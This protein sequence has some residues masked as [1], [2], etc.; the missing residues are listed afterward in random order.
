M[1]IEMRQQSCIDPRLQDWVILP[2]KTIRNFE[3]AILKCSNSD[4]WQY[5]VTLFESFFFFFWKGKIIYLKKD[6]Y[7]R[8]GRKNTETRSIGIRALYHI[9]YNKHYKMRSGKGRTLWISCLANVSAMLWENWHTWWN[10]TRMEVDKILN[11]L[12]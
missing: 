2:I 7:N 8:L 4:I 1:G 11:S 6:E 9:L 10:S 12:K 3:I 5:R